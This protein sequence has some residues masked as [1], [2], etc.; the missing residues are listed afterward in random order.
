MYTGFSVMDF[1]FGFLVRAFSIGK[2]QGGTLL[3]M[4]DICPLILE[5]VVE[6]VKMN[7][8]LGP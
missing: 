2:I 3:W 8:Y 4:P 5:G 7:I 6:A 1:V